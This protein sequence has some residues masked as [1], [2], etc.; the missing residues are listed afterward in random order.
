MQL[1]SVSFASP[2]SEKQAGHSPCGLLAALV[3]FL[4]FPSKSMAGDN[5]IM[6]FLGS[7]DLAL[8]CCPS[9]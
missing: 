9:L 8:H 4:G 1:L 2:H 5:C 6:K 7:T 3:E